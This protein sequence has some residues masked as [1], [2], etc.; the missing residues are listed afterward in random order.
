MVRRGGD[1]F[2]T[3]SFFFDL[4]RV[5]YVHVPYCHSKCAYCDFYSTPSLV[6]MER[7]VGAI[8]EEYAMRSS[9]ISEPHRT[10][11]IGGGTPSVLPAESLGRIVSALPAVPGEFTLE[12]NPE[13]V[14]RDAVARW[15]GLGINRVS[16]GVQSFVDAELATV[17]RRHSAAVAI[18]AVEALRM[19]GIDNFSLDLIYGLPGQNM[20]SWRYSLDT[21]LSLR[22]A[23]FSAYILSYEPRT[24]LT[25]MVKAGRIVPAADDLILDMYAYLCEASAA[26]GYEHYEI[27]NFALPGFRARHNSGYWDGTPY[28]GLGPS[29]HSFDGSVRRFNHADIK[30]YLDRI[31]GGH[32]AYE[33]EDEDENNRF[34]DILIT[35]L[36]TAAGLSLDRVN[37]ARR[38]ALL[39]DAEPHLRSG[40]LVLTSDRRL[41]IPEFSWPLSD[42]ILRDLIQV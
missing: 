10:I 3:F 42:A 21:L 28:L 14:S 39:A 38:R 32:T 7:T 15:R 37:P 30:T 8:A 18:R 31:E 5:I 9:E 29:A 41:F 27:S 20:D 34:N 22:P 35:S 6:T 33:V 12:V 17:R 24:L 2:C 19:G 1:F 23:H 36:R 4:C 26:R 16:M 11:Y 13:D 40:S 25:A